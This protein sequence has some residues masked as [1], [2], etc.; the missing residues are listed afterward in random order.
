MMPGMRTMLLGLGLGLLLLA[1]GG[2]SGDDDAAGDDDVDAQVDAAVS[3]DGGQLADATPTVSNVV[4]FGQGAV[5]LEYSKALVTTVTDVPQLVIIGSDAASFD[6]E[7]E[8]PTCVSLAALLPPDITPGTYECGAAATNI[9]VEVQKDENAY[10]ARADVPGSSCTITV[11]AAGAV[12]APVTVTA[13]TA[14]LQITEGEGG[15]LAIFSASLA[16]IRA[17]DE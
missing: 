10:A 7:N 17:A 4:D 9:S 1:C 3:V 11:G 16:A 2:C 15:G 6:C 8:D 12:G 13:L 14:T 5:T